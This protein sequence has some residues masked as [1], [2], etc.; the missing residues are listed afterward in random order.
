[1]T[2]QQARRLYIWRGRAIVLTVATLAMLASSY[3]SQ[4]TQ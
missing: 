3:C 1:M 4:I 2:D